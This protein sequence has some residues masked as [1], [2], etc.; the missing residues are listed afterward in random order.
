[1]T[2]VLQAQ[3][4]STATFGAGALAYNPIGN[5]WFNLGNLFTTN[6]GRTTY[7]SA[8][9]LSLLSGGVSAN[10][11]NAASTLKLRKAGSAVNSI[12]TIGASTTGMF[13]DASNTD[14]VAVADIFDCIYDTTASISGTITFRTLATLFEATTNT[15]TKLISAGERAFTVVASSFYGLAGTIDGTSTTENRAEQYMGVAGTLKRLGCRVI[16]NSGATTILRSRING[17]NGNLSVT[18]TSSTT[19]VFE[20]TSNTDTIAVGDLSN[21]H[22]DFNVAT[23]NVTITLMWSEFESTADEGLILWAKPASGLTINAFPR[24]TQIGGAIATAISTENDARTKAQ[25]AFTAKNLSIYISSNSVN[26]TMT[27]TLKKGGVDTALTVPV[28]ATSTGRFSDTSNT[29]AIAA[30]DTLTYGI[31]SAGAGTSA[32]RTISMAAEYASAPPPTG[33]IKDI[34]GTG[35]IPWAR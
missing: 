26:A 3:G 7:R 1:M 19:G 8:G 4:A 16:S 2:K 23:P 24:F 9:T 28:G 29:V 17:G 6:G 30:T 13:E 27:C 33:A 20:D 5:G 15:V 22:C 25:V 32:W 12:L 14:A 10:N 18:I 31:T 34:I 21:Y 11:L 35:I